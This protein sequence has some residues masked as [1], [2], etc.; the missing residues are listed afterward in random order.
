MV[1]NGEPIPDSEPWH[2]P[3]RAVRRPER[4]P[5]D[6]RA[7]VV[8]HMAAMSPDKLARLA[9]FACDLSPDCPGCR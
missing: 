3:A 7:I 9:A 6:Y 2:P 1:V 8:A 4:S 5:A